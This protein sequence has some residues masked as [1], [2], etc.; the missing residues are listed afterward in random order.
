MPE[1]YKHIQVSR[2]IPAGQ[3]KE[4]GWQHPQCACSLLRCN[5]TAQDLV[6][7][8]YKY[9]MCRSCDVPRMCC[10]IT[11]TATGLLKAL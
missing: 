10:F 7:R 6:V 2:S 4:L 5:P 1:E 11:I 3:G 8:L 9:N